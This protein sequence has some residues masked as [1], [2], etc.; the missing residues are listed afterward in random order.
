MGLGTLWGK[1]LTLDKT[2]KAA[3]NVLHRKAVRGDCD[4]AAALAGFLEDRGD[5]QK[6][7]EV[8]RQCIQSGGTEAALYLADIESKKGG[9]FGDAE[10]WFRFAVEHGV[11]G[12]RNDFG[13][14]LSEIDRTTEAEELFREA[15]E[16][17]DE[18]AVGNLGKLYFD[19]R[20]Y[21]SAHLWLK[22]ASD[23]GN[24]SAFPYLARIEIGRDNREVAS[25]YLEEAL[26]RDAD[27][28]ELANALYLWKFCLTK[29]SAIA[30]EEAFKESLD[31]A[32]E[33]HFHFANWLNSQGRKQEAI[34]QHALAADL[35]EVNS[36]LNLAIILD[37][38]ERKEE[39]ERHLRQGMAGGD[40]AAAAGLARFLADQGNFEE[41]PDVINEAARLGHPQSDISELWDMYRELT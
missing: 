2:E 28:A 9:D 24:C 6:A 5:L 38:M 18:L 1:L 3:V 26:K 34:D 29:E 32:A 11:D 41:V 17:G 39:A 33:A 35:G 21:E 8:L 14:F 10:H 16:E 30:I 4:A 37:D 13:C 22:M 31:G 15:A 40:G 12:A 23:S 36:H 20:D 27:G 7:G 25:V 19:L